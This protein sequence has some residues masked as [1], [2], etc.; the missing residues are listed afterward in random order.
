MKTRHGI[1][2]ALAFAAVLIGT[3]GV[4]LESALRAHAPVARYGEAAAVV[5]APQSVSMLIKQP[6][7]EPETQRRPLTERARVPVAA[8][9]RLR[10]VPGVRDVVADVS[11]PVAAADGRAFTGHNWSRLASL[12]TG[13]APR[14]AGEVALEQASGAAV[15][16]RVM[17]QVNGAPRPYTVTG[18]V[19]E[20]AYFAPETAVALSGRPSEADAL[21]VYT[22]GGAETAALREAVPGLKVLTGAARGD[23]EDLSVATARPD[24][25]EMGAS[26]G[27]VA[28][29]TTLVVAGG[30]IALSIRERAREFALLRTVGATPGQVRAQIVRENVRAAV[31]AGLLG[32]TLSLPAGAAMHAAMAG[33]GVLPGGLG[34]SLSPLP[35]LAALLIAVLTAAVSALLASLRLARIRPVQALGEAAVERPGLPRWRVGAGGLFL[36]LGLSALGASAATSGATAAVSVG[37]LVISLIIATAFLGPLIARIGVR[38]LGGTVR[39]LDPVAGGLAAHAAGA[40]ALRAGAVLTPVALAVAFAGVQLFVQ[41]TMVRATE[42]QAREA[43][44]ATQV[45]VSAGPG[46]PA[47]AAAAVRATPGVTAATAVKRTTVVM[48]V[49]EL[50]EKQLRS[51]P[52]RGVGAGGLAATTDPGV[53][54]GRLGELRGETVALSRDVAGGTRVGAIK[55]LWLGDGTRLRP[56]VVAIYERGLGLG[57]VLLPRDLVAA[58]ATSPLDDHVLVSGEADLRPVAARYA[59]A[60]V[61]TAGAF[62]ARVSEELRLQG[63]LSGVV[64]AA[65][66]GFIVIGLVTTLATATAARRG[67]FALLRLAG[68]TRRQV[69]RSLRLEAVVVLGTGLATGALIAAVTLLVFA[70]AVTGLPLP[71]VPPVP[72]ALVL[73]LVAG[74]GAAAMLLPA[75]AL[76]RG[77][78][79]GTP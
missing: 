38:V 46:L 19:A 70:T 16:R 7:S 62:G 11:F 21:L 69:L 40:A 73:L 71:S 36:V 78:S 34:L 4:L 9:Q 23:A 63:F 10:S 3:F 76:L 8:A 77:D 29:M 15:G 18:L 68:A 57:D 2:V 41:S 48:A 26:L 28:V 50:G 54:S 60:R 53:V 44:R 32:G 55:P 43:T 51:L 30:L 20:G 56:R 52:A 47:E 45:L 31:A 25:V 22:G 5:T 49:N 67:E 42:V 24:V 27:S 61:V 64:V 66:C 1:F 74:S 72:A 35:A 13:R 37:G 59:G 17:L 33:R 79:P 6:G 65:I 14:T 12:R 75:R 39:R 58:H